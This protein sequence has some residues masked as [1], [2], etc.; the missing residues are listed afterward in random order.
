M[1]NE[2]ESRGTAAR[3]T[4]PT[5]PRTPRASTKTKLAET[6]APA[7]NPVIEAAVAEVPVATPQATVD[8]A[9]NLAAKNVNTGIDQDAVRRRAYE[10]YEQRG[11]L[12]G[13]HEQDWYSAEQEL[14]GR[15][16]SRSQN[17]GRKADSQRSDS[18][19]TA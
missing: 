18:Q 11:R 3:R 1:A 19:R 13:Y 14:S 17:S 4:T 9:R 6:I 12:D 10:L 7:T 16:Q 2:K 5:T 8:P 15:K